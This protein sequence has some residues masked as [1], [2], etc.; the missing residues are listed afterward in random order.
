MTAIDATIDRLLTY[1]E[2]QRDV[3]FDQIYEFMLREKLRL[4]AATN[5]IDVLD[6]V[7][8]ETGR[9]DVDYD[10]HMIYSRSAARRPTA[11][12]TVSAG[13]VEPPG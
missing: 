4:G 3:S 1:V 13:A 9:I 6:L 10:D 11:A 12:A 7:A 2:E 8:Y 5:P